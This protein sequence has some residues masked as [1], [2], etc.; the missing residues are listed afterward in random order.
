[1]LCAKTVAPSTP[2]MCAL[3]CFPL[4]QLGVDTQGGVLAVVDSVPEEILLLW[5][6]ILGV[7]L[8]MLI[9]TMLMLMIT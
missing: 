3:V 9:L 8:T 4:V 6:A 2:R 5:D 7:M 1:M